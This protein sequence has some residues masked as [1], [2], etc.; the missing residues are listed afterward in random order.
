MAAPP[1][2]RSGSATRWWAR[3]APRGRRGALRAAGGGEAS[4]G[5]GE[6][7]GGDRGLFAACVEEGAEGR[8]RSQLRGPPSALLAAEGLAQ[9]AEPEGSKGAFPRQCCRKAE[10]LSPAHVSHNVVAVHL[11]VLLFFSPLFVVRTCGRM[12]RE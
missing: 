7:S 6:V 9:A 12:S 4:G 8:H 1:A 11:S 5:V 10:P 3:A 2:A